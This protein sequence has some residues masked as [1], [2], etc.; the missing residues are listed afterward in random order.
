MTALRRAAHVQVEDCP[1][2]R[3]VRKVI[4]SLYWL[5]R[6]AQLLHKVVKIPAFTMGCNRCDA[7]R[8]G[9]QSLR[10]RPETKQATE[11]MQF[12]IRRSIRVKGQLR[13]GE[14][15]MRGDLATHGLILDEC[16]V[17]VVSVNVA[18]IPFEI[19]RAAIALFPARIPDQ[20]PNRSLS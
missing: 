11:R 17:S 5:C 2:T 9:Y 19:P 12:A 8:V 4:L 10:V 13:L 15:Q 1:K 20:K 16:V 18:S 14:P 6:R 3:P 7:N